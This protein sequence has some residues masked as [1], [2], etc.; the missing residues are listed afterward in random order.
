LKATIR[1]LILF[2]LI[3]AATTANSSI[4][5]I[6]EATGAGVLQRDNSDITAENGVAVES[7]D[8]AVTKDGRMRIDFVDATRVDVTEHSRLVIDEFVYDP[9]QNK[10]AL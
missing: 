10:G 8:A 1:Q 7:Y 9:A 6:S 4:G 3:S 2:S 5:T